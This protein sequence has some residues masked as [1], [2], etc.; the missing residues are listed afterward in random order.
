MTALL[1]APD[2]TV[3]SVPCPLFYRDCASEISSVTEQSANMNISAI[4][5]GLLCAWMALLV[6][7]FIFLGLIYVNRRRSR[8]C[9]PIVD[10]VPLL[11]HSAEPLYA[12]RRMPP[13]SSLDIPPQ[14]V[15]EQEDEEKKKRKAVSPLL[16]YV[17]NI[18]TPAA[19]S[20][21][22]AS[23]PRILSPISLVTSFSFQGLSFG[24]RPEQT[25]T[26][27][28][29]HSP[30]PRTFGQSSFAKTAPNPALKALPSP[31]NSSASCGRKSP[32]SRI[33]DF[34]KSLD[35]PLSGP[36]TSNLRRDVICKTMVTSITK[37]HPWSHSLP[38]IHK[39]VVINSSCHCSPV[40]TSGVESYWSSSL[41][42]ISRHRPAPVDL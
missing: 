34:S 17:V 2:E 18:L 6:I 31:P 41:V 7:C 27:A 25:S 30:F 16:E 8:A 3:T 13:P 42:S 33:R 23:S 9:L 28:A 19:T 29:P 5:F 39:N 22:D 4:I 10:E 32:V 35:S 21:G 12:R 40:T 26:K 1:L 38:D 36:S 14:D 20:N 15:P 24:K 11:T 37:E